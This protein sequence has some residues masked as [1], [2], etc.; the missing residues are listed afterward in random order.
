MSRD[1]MSGAEVVRC[2][3]SGRPHRYSWL[4]W[5]SCSYVVSLELQPWR[6]RSAG[7]SS[8]AGSSVWL[9]V[10]SWPV[11]GPGAPTAFPPPGSLP[12]VADTRRPS[13]VRRC[14]HRWTR[15]V[16][17]GPDSRPCP[18]GLPVGGDVHSRHR[19][20]SRLPAPAVAR[21]P[22]PVGN[23]R[24]VNRGP[25]PLPADIGR[26][27]FGLRE[28]RQG[29]SGR[30]SGCSPGNGQVAG[31]VLGHVRELCRGLSEKLPWRCS[32]GVCRL[33]I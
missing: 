25:L 28:V 33:P 22:V 19:G 26:Q 12:A 15:M 14:L 17:G 4:Y 10:P 30:Q 21:S 24:R 20:R 7:P 2:R 31:S 32:D 1:I 23:Y 11:G 5:L 8:P 16:G 3:V 6:P 18:D 9:A 29:V 13:G 27:L